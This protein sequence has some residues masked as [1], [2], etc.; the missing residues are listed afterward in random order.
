MRLL[1]AEDDLPL[2]SFVRSGLEAE[3]YTVDLASDGQQA[4]LLA[5]SKNYDLLILDLS[6]PAMDGLEVLKAVRTKGAAVPILVLTGRNRIKDRVGCLDLGADDCLIK[7]FSY[8]ELSARVRALLRRGRQAF[9]P[10]LRFEDLEITRSERKVRR[11]G[12]EI[13]L[14]TKE[15]SL[16]EY[17]MLHAGEPVSRELILEHIWKLSPGMVTNVVDVYINYLR[18]KVDD[19]FEKKLINSVRGVGYQLGW[20]APSTS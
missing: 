3:N 7:P 8:L 19:G 16:M 9:E 17:L 2:A 14:T 4:S 11:A 5:D 20:R 18:R 1:M 12:S 15:Y 13:F 10:V 6:L